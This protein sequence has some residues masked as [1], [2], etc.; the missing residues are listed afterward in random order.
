MRRWIS[1]FLALSL[2]VT[3]LVLPA[4]AAQM[5]P[6]EVTL[7]A[8]SNLLGITSVDGLYRDNTFYVS[9][10]TI[11]DFTAGTYEEEQTG[12]RV[13]FLFNHRMREIHADV[14]GVAAEY[15]GEDRYEFD[16]PAISHDGALYVSMV[17]LLRY[18]GCT[19]QFAENEK[20][21][22]HMLVHCPYTV[23]DL[24]A[25]YNACQDKYFSWSEAEG[26]FAENDLSVIMSAWNTL[27]LGYDSNLFKY[28]LAMILPE[29]NDVSEDVYEDAIYQ[30]LCNEGYSHLSDENV[31]MQIIHS[32]METIGT[33]IDI[34]GFL[35]DKIIAYTDAGKSMKRMISGAYSAMGVGAATIG[36]WLKNMEKTYHYL[37]LTGNQRVL[38]ED[39]LCQYQKGDELY[40]KD[41]PLFKAGQTIQDIVDDEDARREEVDNETVESFLYT[42]ADAVVSGA[43]AAASSS[44]ELVMQG[45]KASIYLLNRMPV[46]SEYLERDTLMTMAMVDLKIQQLAMLRIEE[47]ARQWQRNLLYVGSSDTTHQRQMRSAMIL[48]LKASLTARENLIASEYVTEESAAL[49]EQKAR[50][51]AILL[52][53]AENAVMVP[54]GIPPTVE[55]DLSWIA[56]LVK[57]EVIVTAAIETE[58]MPNYTGSIVYPT[59]YIPGRDEV[60]EKINTHVHNVLL[61]PI[62]KTAEDQKALAAEMV[63][64]DWNAFC[65]AWLYAA[66]ASG[67]ALSIGMEKTDFNYSRPGHARSFAVF[68]LRTG[69]QLR[70]T[71]LLEPDNPDARQQLQALLRTALKDVENNLPLRD[72]MRVDQTASDLVVNKR[73]EIWYLGAEGL[74]V[75]YAFSGVWFQANGYCNAVVG[76][77]ELEGILDPAFLPEIRSG[78][79]ECVIRSADAAEME[80]TYGTQ[81]GKALII[82][83]KS[84]DVTVRSED[85]E[86]ILFYASRID[87]A[88][89]WV[90]EAEQY[91]INHR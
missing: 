26:F 55:E 11:C 72:N 19:V 53:K 74:V 21:E 14:S 77:E 42:A 67:N 3:M 35:S 40:E 44:L 65:S 69:A 13:M 6:V 63:G 12:E 33:L 45:Y 1:L 83:G 4:A 76:Y 22:V 52:Y 48:A 82:N 66:Y 24:I 90:P 7:E 36:D 84:V 46:V 54:L 85:H 32:Q 89:A 51:T 2:L 79:G 80:Q 86:G 31:Q 71:D 47:C 59:V 87:N 28:I 50:E 56:L 75:S 34:N 68:D 17:H 16:L 29:H 91:T 58:T 27:I 88:M 61:G 9:A 15:F 57:P 25:E 49:M 41:P 81:T 30:I 64:T 73:S 38:L 37:R 62:Q 78:D 39:T 70:L 23:L 8:F 20:A 10:Q 5:E 60:A 43:I 18:L